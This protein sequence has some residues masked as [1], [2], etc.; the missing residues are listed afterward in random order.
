MDGYEL[1]SA[2]SVGSAVFG[3]LL[4]EKGMLGGSWWRWRPGSVGGEWLVLV[5]ENLLGL[6]GIGRREEDRYG[7]ERLDS[8]PLVLAR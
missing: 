4:E 6:T 3:L 5:L 2:G 8:C 1:W 7:E